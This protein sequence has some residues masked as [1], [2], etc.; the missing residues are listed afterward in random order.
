MV[1]SM[2]SVSCD[3]IGAQ[4]FL[5]EWSLSRVNISFDHAGASEEVLAG[6]SD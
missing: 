5:F 3:T 2:D 6:A 1:N 4:A